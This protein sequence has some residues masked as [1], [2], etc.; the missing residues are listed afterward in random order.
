MRWSGELFMEEMDNDVKNMAQKTK[1]RMPERPESRSKEP[2][3][4]PKGR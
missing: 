4:G 1:S 3:A 2:K